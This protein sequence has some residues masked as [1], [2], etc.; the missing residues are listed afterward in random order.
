VDERREPARKTLEASQYLVESRN[1][2]F[3]GPHVAAF[4]VEPG[5]PI[6][7]GE[8]DRRFVEN[9]D[10]LAVIEGER[11]KLGIGVESK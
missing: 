8:H 1:D 11:A 7:A 3:E 5:K 2:R 9:V 6:E 4:D 10:Q